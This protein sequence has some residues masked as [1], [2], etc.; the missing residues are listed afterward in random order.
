VKY[1]PSKD[2]FGEVSIVFSWILIFNVVLTYGMETAFFRFY[3]DPTV[4]KKAMKTTLTAVFCTTLI[5]A[6]I[7]FLSLDTI[8]SLTEIKASYWQWVIGVIALDTLTV[9]PFAFMRA[10]G[11]TMNYAVVKLVN[12]FISVGLSALFFILLPRW[13]TI[14]AYLPTDKIELFFIAFFTASLLTFVIVAKPY[15]ARWEL[16]FKLWKKMLVYGAPILIAGLA[17]AINETFDKILLQWLSPQDIAKE[18]VGIYSACYRLAIGMT[19][20][21]TAFKL[22]VEPFF[23]S[24][25][26]NENAKSMYAQITKI[27][28]LLGSVALFVYIVMID[29]IKPILVPEPKYWEAMNVVPP[30]LIAFLFFGIYQSLSVWYKVTDKTRYGAIISVIGAALTI[31]LNVI[32]IPVIGFMASAIT[33]CVAYGTMMLLSYFIG[34]RHYK[35]PYDMKSITT[36]LGTA[37]LFTLVYFYYF[38]E[39][40]GVNSLAL[41]GLGIIMT[42]V[43]LVIIWTGNKLFFK[44][45]IAKKW[46]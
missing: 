43:L 4:G 19:L 11:K 3:S 33:T 21:A 1:L 29:I 15:F 7:A 12:V 23:F 36:S 30:V 20:Y 32:F 46:K 25:S 45:I 8:A 26:R 34:R 27:F 41:Y 24:E 28:V 31:G 22:G 5:A 39:L 14:S 35:I 9:I 18:Q 16:D 10:Q 6:C 44:T 37:I 38:R 17:F 42:F 2:A 40:L 13:E